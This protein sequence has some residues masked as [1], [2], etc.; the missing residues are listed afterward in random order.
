VLARSGL[1]AQ[2]DVIPIG[3]VID[4]IYRGNIKIILHHLYNP[5]RLQSCKFT[6]GSKIAQIAILK[7]ITN[8]EFIETETVTETVR[9]NNGFGSTDKKE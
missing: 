5:K 3:G 7:N 6:A 4:K 8:V 9:G 2:A 1:A